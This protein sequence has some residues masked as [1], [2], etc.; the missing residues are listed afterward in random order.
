MFCKLARAAPSS[1]LAPP[2]ACPGLLLSRIRLRVLAYTHLRSVHRVRILLYYYPI[3]SQIPHTHIIAILDTTNQTPLCSAPRVSKSARPC[4]SGLQFRGYRM[5]MSDVIIDH[6]ARA[7]PLSRLHWHRHINLGRRRVCES[8]SPNI[9][10]Y[11]PA[12]PDH[13]CLKT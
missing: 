2:S 4:R 12:L 6:P 5:L 10:R 3:S 9:T 11:R 8:P 13:I 1:V 7:G